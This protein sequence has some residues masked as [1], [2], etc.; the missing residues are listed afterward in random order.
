MKLVAEQGLVKSK[1]IG[2]ADS[3]AALRSIV[4]RD[5]GETYRA[6][7]ECMAKESG[8]ETPIIDVLVRLDPQEQR[9]E[10]VERG[11]DEQDGRCGEDRQD[12]GRDDASRLQAGTRGRSRNGRHRRCA[13]LR[14]RRGRYD[15][16]R[17]NAE[18]GEEQ[19]FGCRP[20]VDVGRSCEIIADLA[21]IRARF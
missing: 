16:A 21:I 3:N 10:A 11:L 5:N 8:V 12:E 4:R 18:D 14:S 17:R 7:L 2:V 9:R 15:D 13:D 20:R 1:R 19:S 6:M